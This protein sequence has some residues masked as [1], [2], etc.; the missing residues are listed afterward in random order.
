MCYGVD[1]NRNFDYQWNHTKNHEDLLDKFRSAAT[2]TNAMLHSLL[3]SSFDLLVIMVPNYITL[4][5]QARGKIA[6]VE[7]TTQRG[8]P[9]RLSGLGARDSD[10]GQLH[11]KSQ[12]ED[13][14]IR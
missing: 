7:T 12:T 9:W 1:L 10:L 6:L 13:Q 11:E 4:Y 14:G 5:I 8:I 2:Q 3:H